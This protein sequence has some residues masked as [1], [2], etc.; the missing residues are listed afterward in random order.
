LFITL[1][2][3]DLRWSQHNCEIHS[4]EQPVFICNTSA[5]N[6]ADVKMLPKFLGAYYINSTMLQN[7]TRNSGKILNHTFCDGRK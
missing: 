5:T 2:H 1:L 4:V 6:T 3:V 7:T